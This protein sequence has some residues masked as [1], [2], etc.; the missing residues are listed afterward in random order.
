MLTVGNYTLTVKNGK[1][2]ELA[3]IDSSGNELTTIISSS[4]TYDDSSD[5]AVTVP[6]G[7]GIVDASARTTAIKI[8]ANKVANSIVGGSGKDTISAGNGN[9]TVYGGKGNDSING[10]NGNDYLQGDTGADKLLGGAGDDTL[11]G[12]TSNDMLTGGDGA[13]TFI[14]TSGKDVITDFGDDDLLQITGD[15]TAA[16]SSSTNAITFKV[17]STASAITLKNVTATGAFN[18]NGDVYTIS[19][20]KLVK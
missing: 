2:K 20:T 9:D 11:W 18:I 12:G 3:L 10:G 17:G 15:W 7:I 6:S 4:I 14:Y 16:Y 19:G 13:D 5:A 8:I 1:D